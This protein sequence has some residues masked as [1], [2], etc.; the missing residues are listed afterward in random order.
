[1]V[2][3]CLGIWKVSIVWLLVVVVVG[4]W[5]EKVLLFM[6]I[7]VNLVGCELGLGMGGSFFLYFISKVE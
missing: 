2:C 4:N 7:V 5:W 3:S 6:D 1:M